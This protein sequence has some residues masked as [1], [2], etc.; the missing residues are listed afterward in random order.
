[1]C[2]TKVGAGQFVSVSLGELGG[3]AGVMLR[4]VSKYSPG[5]DHSAHLANMRLRRLLL[6]CLGEEPAIWV[7]MRRGGECMHDAAP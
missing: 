5:E 1:M 2:P 4:F 3:F 7:W 6:D